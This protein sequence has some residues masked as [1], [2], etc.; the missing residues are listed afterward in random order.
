MEFACFKS[1]G[2]MGGLNI[3]FCISHPIYCRLFTNHT[4]IEKYDQAL[5][6]LFE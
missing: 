3:K 6:V 4:N 2:N 5:D 1:R